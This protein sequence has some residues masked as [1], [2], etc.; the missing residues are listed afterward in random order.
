MSPG[1]TDGPGSLTGKE[2]NEIKKEMNEFNATCL[3]QL[4]IRRPRAPAPDEMLIPVSHDG[5][6]L[7]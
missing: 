4:S 2:N 1:K 5:T 3:S 6:E 7:H